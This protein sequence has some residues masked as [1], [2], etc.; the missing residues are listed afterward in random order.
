MDRILLCIFL[1]VAAASAHAG[2]GLYYSLD[3]M[4]HTMHTETQT[5]I[6]Y[7]TSSPAPTSESGTSEKKYAHIGLDMGYK[8]KRRMTHHFFMTPELH[9]SNFDSNT[10]IYGTNL[11]LGTEYARFGVYGIVGVSHIDMLKKN[12]TNYGLGTE[13][14][15]TDTLSLNLEWQRY[16]TMKEETTSVLSLGSQTV[17]TAT[18]TNRDLDAIKLGISIYFH[19]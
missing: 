11:K 17:T 3:A 10:L 4:S 8:Y 6:T 16:S 12:T 2:S 5:D 14:R 1:F 13:Y 7:S 15:I 19:E 18:D 9:V